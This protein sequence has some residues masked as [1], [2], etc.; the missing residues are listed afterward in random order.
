MYDVTISGE[1]LIQREGKKF[2]CVKTNRKLFAVDQ[3]KI[4]FRKIS[5]FNYYH[6]YIGGAD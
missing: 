6:H 2:F 4:S 5:T 1:K 3:W